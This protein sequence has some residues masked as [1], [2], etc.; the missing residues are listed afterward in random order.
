MRIALAALLALVVLAPA[1]AL[2]RTGSVECRYLTQRISFFG[3]RLER[4]E[5]LDNAVWEKRLE[6]H[7]DQLRDQRAQSCPGYGADEQ[8]MAAFMDLVR[9]GGQ[10]A[11]SYFTLGAF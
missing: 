4:A 5:Q 10:A 2:A 9:L 8:A 11:L 7:L 6:N 1:A 3:A